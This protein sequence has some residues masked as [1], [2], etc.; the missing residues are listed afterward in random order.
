MK[1]QFAKNHWH[2]I[3]TDSQKVQDNH[4]SF[5]FSIFKKSVLLIKVN[6]LLVKNHWKNK[7]LFQIHPSAI[8]PKQLILQKL[9]VKNFFLSS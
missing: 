2:F 7:Q 6:V 8:C 9:T 3:E 5:F 4:R 1:A